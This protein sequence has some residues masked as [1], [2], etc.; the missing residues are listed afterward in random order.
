M[1]RVGVPREKIGEVLELSKSDVAIH[2]WKLISSNDHDR[3]VQLL[4]SDPSLI[5]VCDLRGNTPMHMAVK[6]HKPR[7]VADLYIMGADPDREN[8]DAVTPRQLAT[9]SDSEQIREIFQRCKSR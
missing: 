6:T 2:L 3:T 4:E 1:A 7:L 9:S 5:L 8:I